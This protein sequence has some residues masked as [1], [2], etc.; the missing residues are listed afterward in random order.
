M[1]ADGDQRS[2]RSKLARAST[3]VRAKAETWTARLSRAEA[4]I[5]RVST[6]PRVRPWL[7]IAALLLFV[8][9][10]AASFSSLPHDLHFHWWLLL[11]LVVVTTPV[12]VAANAA[13]YR[14]IAAVADISTTWPGAIRL[15][16]LANAANLLPLPG[17]VAIRTQALRQRGSSYKRALA[18]NAAAGLAW[19]GTGCIAIASL[20]LA[21][22]IDLAAVL[23]L[24][25]GGAGAL[26]LTR[27]MI[28]RATNGRSLYVRFGQLLLVEGF[29]VLVSGTRIYVA[30]HAIGLSISPAQAVALSGS[31][32]IAAA[33]GIA[34]AGLGIREAVAGGI[35]AAVG[36]DLAQAVAAMA[37]DRIAGQLGMA[38]LSGV[39]LVGPRVAFRRGRQARVTAVIGREGPKHP[40]PAQ[41]LTPSGD[42]DF[43]R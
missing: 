5:N 13:E 22:G 23:A 18:A 25:A 33:I 9:L 4:S 39:F 21:S 29:T 16:V 36:V 43:A 8:S 15:S 41:H 11:V 17:G 24:A 38:L 3:S 20:F 10:S 27:Y 2:G 7:L 31:E 42:D 6:A 30:F 34:P 37:Y 1:A 40:P 14:V 32:I 26:A 28:K 19:A 12:T 35:G